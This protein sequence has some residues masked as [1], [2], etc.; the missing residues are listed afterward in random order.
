MKHTTRLCACVKTHAREYIWAA[1]SV[2]VCALGVSELSSTSAATPSGWIQLLCE[3]RAVR[4]EGQ[5]HHQHRRVRHNATIEENTLLK[6]AH[7]AI[8]YRWARR[9]CFQC[10]SSGWLVSVFCAEKTYSIAYGEATRG[11]DQ[12]NIANDSCVW[13]CHFVPKLRPQSCASACACIATSQ[14][15]AYK[16]HVCVLFGEI[17]VKT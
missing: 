4:I 10:A 6:I 7:T 15:T 13:V 1:H 2:C 14:R 12:K 16:L 17:T 9:Q 5:H 3:S 8:Y 11:G